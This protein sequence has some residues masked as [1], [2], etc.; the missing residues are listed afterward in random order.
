MIV[1]AIDP[2]KSGALAIL[3][4][5]DFVEVFDVPMAG[6]K[7][8]WTEWGQTW[9]NAI[10]LAA[11][12]LFLIEDVHSMPKQGV[13][14]SFTF[15]ETLG[16]VHGVALRSAPAARFEWPSPSLWMRKMGMPRAGDNG[17]ASREEARRLMP[18]LIPS[19]VRVKDHGRAEAALIAY[20]GRKY[21]CVT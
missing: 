14:S 1:A 4:P 5:D 13:T 19:L 21:L 7:P 10:G 9:G 8:A 12:D 16:F 20:Y 17:S 2:G 3:Y 11:P 6:N 15:G 18:A